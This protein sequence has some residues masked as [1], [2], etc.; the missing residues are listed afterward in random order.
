M[1]NIN[2]FLAYI[3]AEIIAIIVGLPAY[4]IG[5]TSLLVAAL[6][7][8]LIATLIYTEYITKEEIYEE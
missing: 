1:K 4:I 8:A 2:T 3:C 6:F 7:G 5:D